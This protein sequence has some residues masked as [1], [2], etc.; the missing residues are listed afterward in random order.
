MGE[1]GD[2][3]KKMGK[4]MGREWEIEGRMARKTSFFRAEIGGCL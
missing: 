4:L 1:E 3:M 2:G